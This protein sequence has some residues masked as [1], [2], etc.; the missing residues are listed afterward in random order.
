MIIELLSDDKRCIAAKRALALKPLPYEKLF[1]LP[2]PSFKG[3]KLFGTDFGERELLSLVSG[4]DALLGYGIPESVKVELSKKGA[5]VFDAAECEKFLLKNAYLTAVGSIGE[6]ITA[7]QHSPEKTEFLIVGYGRI[8][9]ELT[10]LLVALGAVPTVMSGREGVRK[11]LMQ[12]GIKAIACAEALPASLDVIINTAPTPFTD[13]AGVELLH[14]RGVSIFDL[15]SG[16]NFGGSPFVE[17]LSGIPGKFYP[18]CAGEAYA[19]VVG[20]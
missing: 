12:N 15:A 13:R 6:I 17:R 9:K 1:I 18:E 4:A 19:E 2:I 5:R 3:G 20:I 8:G 14:A 16:E 11:E 10:R 7:R